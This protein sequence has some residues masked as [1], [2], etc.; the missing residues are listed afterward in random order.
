MQR[1]HAAVKNG[2]VAAAQA[3]L[4]HPGVD[5]NGRGNDGR[6]ALHTSIAL[7]NYDMMELLL[8]YGADPDLTCHTSFHY[9]YQLCSADEPPIVT[10]TR[11]TSAR[12][13]EALLNAGSNPDLQMKVRYWINIFYL[14]MV[15]L[16]FSETKIKHV[17]TITFR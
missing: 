2:N 1:F 17:Q 13:V 14:I 7:N 5:I 3:T 16:H 10:A 4:A 6:T 11:L 15:P 12:F 9:G 8:R